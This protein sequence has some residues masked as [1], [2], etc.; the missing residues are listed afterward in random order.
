MRTSSFRRLLLLGVALVTLAGVST[1]AAKPTRPEAYVLPGKRVFPEGI[2]YQRGSFNF[3]VSSTEDGSI[4]RGHL[5]QTEA[6]V[7]LPG[8]EDGRTTA[9]G[10]KVDRQNRLFIAGGATGRIW[11]YDTDAGGL[12][13]RFE[14]GPGGFLNDVAVVEGRGAFV[15]DS[16][17]PFIYHVPSEAAATPSPEPEPLE[18]WLDLTGTVAEY[19]PGFNLNGIVATRNGRF[20]ITVN[21]ASGRLFRIDV[22]SGEVIEIDLGEARLTGGDGLVLQG[23]TLHAVRGAASEV[24]TVWLSGDLTRGV[25]VARVSDPSFRRPTTAA[26]ARGRLLV[27]NSQFDRRATGDPELPFTVSSIPIP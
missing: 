11:V 19:G 4:F 14:T 13:R 22:R 2:A 17:R 1:A 5:R 18:P 6:E 26:I 9:V 7:L 16:F 8:G 21:A 3:Y 20:L 25:V 15:T 24:A 27:V 12:L 10:L 23:R